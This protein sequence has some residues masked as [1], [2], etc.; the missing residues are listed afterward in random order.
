VFSIRLITSSAPR[1]L[2]LAVL[3]IGTFRFRSPS[4]VAYILWLPRHE[5][6]PPPGAPVAR[7]NR[8][9]IDTDAAA[10]RDLAIAMADR[11]I[12]AGRR[13]IVAAYRRYQERTAR[14]PD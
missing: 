8:S 3:I 7:A 11:N 10:E 9:Q 2:F 13:A 12:A 6:R 5:Y 14:G 1:G 4:L